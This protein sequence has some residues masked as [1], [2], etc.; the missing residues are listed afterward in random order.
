MAKLK[1]VFDAVTIGTNGMITNKQELDYLTPSYYIDSGRGLYI[2]WLLEDAAINSIC[3]L[4]MPNFSIFI[5][6]IS[7]LLYQTL[8]IMYYKYIDLISKTYLL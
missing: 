7:L 5:L 6:K 4:G 1:K 2:I 3:L 8:S